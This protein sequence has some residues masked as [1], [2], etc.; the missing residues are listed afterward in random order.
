MTEST[1]ELEKKVEHP[2]PKAPSKE[3]AA[4][5]CRWWDRGKEADNGL[6]AVIDVDGESIGSIKF[7]LHGKSPEDPGYNNLLSAKI[8]ETFG[9]YDRNA[10]GNA[11]SDCV[12]CFLTSSAV[13]VE[14]MDYDEA[15]RTLESH[16]Y[17]VLTLFQELRPKDSF[18]LMMVT[19][20][21]ILD[22]LSTKEFIA[23][24]CKGSEELRTSR[25]SRGIKLSRLFMEF[26]EKLDKHR[27]PEQQIHVQH[28]HIY[29]EGQAII[30]SNLS[31]GGGR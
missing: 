7:A 8:Y 23:G 14:L 26:K 20:V 12:N 21:I 4:L 17:N 5:V 25:Q 31:T 6:K 13:N 11:F 30:G 16:C 28:N 3:E 19:K 29:N 22:H 9:V 15:K 18:E 2:K 1:K 27:K 10:A 24:A